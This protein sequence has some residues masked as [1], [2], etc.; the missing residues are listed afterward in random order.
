MT[1]TATAAAAATNMA[2]YQAGA[3]IRP[4]YRIEVKTFATGI[5]LLIL[6]VIGFISLM[7]HFVG[8]TVYAVLVIVSLLVGCTITLKAA[9]G[10]PLLELAAMA[11]VALK[12]TA[13]ALLQNLENQMTTG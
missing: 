1:D 3:K 8:M 5:V 13:D 6:L 2:V 11:V 10:R 9:T 4:P 12:E 7:L